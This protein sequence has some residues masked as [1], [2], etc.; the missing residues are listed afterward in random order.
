MYPVI[1]HLEPTQPVNRTPIAPP[2]WGKQETLTGFNLQSTPF[3]DVPPA[4]TMQPGL[5]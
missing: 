3:P 4:S 5:A 1:P 2:I